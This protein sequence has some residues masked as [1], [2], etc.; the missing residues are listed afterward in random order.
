MSATEVQ[1]GSAVRS[2][3]RLRL[4]EVCLEDYDR[5]AALASKFNLCT[6]P[7]PAWEH[8][9]TKNP[10]VQE[11]RGKI[12][13][14]WVLEDS[15]GTISGYLGNVPQTYEFQ[16]K[17]LVAASTRAWVVES[18]FRTYS[19]L[20][21]GTYFQQRNVDLF[22]STTVTA[23]SAAAYNIFSGSPVPVG[24]W[25][26]TLFWITNHRGF[27][28]SFL[29]KRGTAMAKM[30][31]YP[32]SVGVRI[33]DQLRGSRIHRSR[34][35][36]P[37]AVPCPSFDERFDSFWAALKTKKSN[38]LLAVRSREVLEW[39]FK[40]ALQQNWAW[41]YTVPSDSGLAAYAIFRRHDYDQIGLTRM[42]LVDFQCLDQERAADVLEALLQAAM[43]RCQRQCIHMLEV[44]GLPPTLEKRLEAASPH[45]RSLSSWLY[46]YRTSNS[47]LAEKLKSANVWEP[48]LF[49]GDS[50]L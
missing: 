49:D 45:R 42:R 1:P 22:L 31:S 15:Q 43:E 19:P 44:V 8:L 24:V 34:S 16:G 20:L 21:L 29:R 32:L 23:Q 38:I 10:A 35:A 47:S 26:R 50:S 30:A 41:I 11:I 18:A 3:Q 13:M 28:E 6:E 14:G 9:W 7:Y 5:V 17:K 33:R 25:D 40:F 36:A 4:R 46:Y 39:H 2:A 37:V 48:S 12:P 27:V